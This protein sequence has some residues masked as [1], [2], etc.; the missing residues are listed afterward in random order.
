[1]DKDTNLSIAPPS[2]SYDYSS[3][4]NQPSDTIRLLEL[5]PGHIAGEIHGT[6]T[7][8]RLDDKPDYRALSYMWSDEVDSSQIFLGGK[9]LPLRQNLWTLLRRL[10]RDGQTGYPW[11]DAVCV[12]QQDL[13]ERSAQL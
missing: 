8:I 9:F 3:L 12:N 4:E 2:T 10:Q 6:L 7:T 11:A 13:S 1:M 5:L